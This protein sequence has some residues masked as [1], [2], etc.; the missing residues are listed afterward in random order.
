LAANRHSLQNPTILPRFI[1]LLIV[2][3]NVACLSSELTPPPDLNDNVLHLTLIN[4]MADAVQH[5]H[6][7]FDFWSPE[8]ALG[9]PIVRLYQPMSH[10]LVVV[11]YYGMFKL[12]PL[13]TVFVWFRFLAMVLIPLS[14]YGCARLLELPP[15][16]QIAAAALAPLVSGDLFG[17]DLGAYVW[18][19]I[20]LFPQL[21]ATHFLL[22]AVGTGW[23]A[24][25]RGRRWWL[26][27]VLVALTGWSNLL[28]GY[29]AAVT[30]CIVA[31]MPDLPWRTRVMRLGRIGLLAGACAIPKL[32]VW[33]MEPG[34]LSAGESGPRQ[35]M[36]DSYGAARVLHDAFTGHLL[37]AGRLPVVTVLVALGIVVALVRRSPQASFLLVALTAWLA[38]Y[39]GRPFWGAALYLI[40]IT[41]AM[42]L[43][44][45]IGPV[46]I[47]SVLLAA[48]GIAWAWMRFTHDRV[49]VVAALLLILS[50]AIQERRTYLRD[51]AAWTAE[52]RFA[53]ALD[54]ANIE[55]AL[56]VAKA[57]GGRAYAGMPFTWG[58]SFRI[59]QVPVYSLFPVRQIP[60]VGY[61]Y[62]G[63]LPRNTAMYGFNEA[64]PADYAD[65]DVR[66]VI[67]PLDQAPMPNWELIGQFG[68]FSVYKVLAAGLEVR[69]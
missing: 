39:F 9:Q 53:F 27:G 2:A 41:P 47:F 58:K 4:G 10:A 25:R 38:L 65:M 16:A 35:F 69:P 44:R 12:V 20:G 59:G 3:V 48:L 6:N 36:A 51:N 56:A 17:L 40:G 22:F 11:A 63:F 34:R 43:H 1:L 50:P 28:Y 7:P 45:L 37:D 23:Q 18:G 33:L 52:T 15:S 66:T 61:L 32:W 24:I 31:L 30:L 5:G 64:R 55:K 57:R 13:A 62:I 49:L 21:V 19:G 8:I 60:S 42:P 29:V 26:A 68:R 54:G 67:A 14:F 46:Q